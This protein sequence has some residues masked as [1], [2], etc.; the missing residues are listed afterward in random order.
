MTVTVQ[1]RADVGRTSDIDLEA[2]RRRYAEER[3]KRLREEG[4]QQYLQTKGDFSYFVDDPYVERVE[5]QPIETTRQAVVIGGGFGGILTAIRLKKAGIDD[6]M[7]I[8]K[9]GD[10]GGTWYWNRYPG[11]ACDMKS[12]VYLPLLE[13]VGYM[14]PRNYASGQEIHQHAKRLVAHFGLQPHGLFQTEVRELRWLEDESCWLV[15]TVQGDRIRAK[16]VLTATGSFSRPKLP[17]I[18][19]VDRYKGHTFHSSRWDYA[20]TGGSPDGGLT[21]L[22]GKRVAIIGTGATSVQLIPH[23]AEHA[24]HLYVVQRTPSGVDARAEEPLDPEWVASLEPGWQKRL[25]ENFTSLTSGAG[26]EQD[27]I[28]D[29]WTFLFTRI[30]AAASAAPDGNFTLD[31]LL[32]A[33]ELADA[34]KMTEIRARIDVAVRD[35]EVAERLKPWYRRFCK[36]PV[37]HDGFLETFN[38][39]NVTLLDTDGKGIDEI[40]EDAIVVNGAAY[41]VDCIIFASGFEIGADSVVRNGFSVI[42]KGGLDLSDTWSRHGISTFHGMLINGFPNFFIHQTAQGALAANFCHGLDEMSRHMS[43]VIARTEAAGASEV[44]VSKAAETEWVEHCAGVSGL[45]MDFLKTCTPGY[46]NAEGKIDSESIKGY[47]YGLGPMMFFGIIDRW[48]EDGT[49]EGVELRKDGAPIV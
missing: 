3:D 2:L 37:F 14:P 9:G 20:Y 16:Y 38:R 24:G 12:Y 11:L 48:R 30:L 25:I 33:A 26:A 40:T 19:G 8:E 45:M 36:R 6:I 29:G 4:N 47:G 46:Y 41:P 23:L 28:Q 32:L 17:G 1:D 5:R 27:L 21:G 35:P 34:E 43:Y 22:Q 7:I 31:D 44:E 15:S 39:N 49:M 42:G 13:E 18:R 10:F